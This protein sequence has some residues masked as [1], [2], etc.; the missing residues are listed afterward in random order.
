M[1][2][3]NKGF[4]RKIL[5][6]ASPT[7]GEQELQR[8][9]HEWATPFADRIEADMLGN[10]AV[11]INPDAKL[12]VMLAGHC[13]RIGFIVMEI[14]E[15]GY[16]R[17]DP[18]GGIDEATVLGAHVVIRSKKG[19]VPGIFGKV[20]THIQ[21]KEEKERVPLMDEVWIDIGA[22]DKEAAEKLVAVGDYAVYENHVTELSG[23]RIAS[24]ALDNMTGLY[25]IMQTAKNCAERGIDV[26]LY[27]VSTVQEEIGSRGAEVAGNAIKPHIAIA[28]DTT[29][30]IDTPGQPKIRTTPQLSLG[31]G[32]S[33]M[34]GPNAHPI[35][36]R[37]F[38]DAAKNA[39]IPYQLEVNAQEASNDAKSMQVADSGCA[40]GS[41][42][43]PLRNMHTQVEVVD[44]DDV[45][46]TVRL[47]TEFVCSL[48]EDQDLLPINAD[49]DGKF[50][51]QKPVSNAGL[52]K[53]GGFEPKD[54]GPN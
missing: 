52:G 24:P 39:N 14:T 34:R 10:M 15:Q 31:D 19:D 30:A 32:P 22:K 47:L 16:L 13:D 43:I 37:L 26:A 9:L 38:I 40:A 53:L 25:A 29:L 27:A 28:V 42:G 36:T 20:S 4:L 8:Y 7:G 54:K 35:V 49:V 46:N 51:D 23:S 2:A 44:M 17:V 18:L 11:V 48:K 3:D 21:T 41:I 33:I 12:R 6:L 50:V 5:S 1:T 45:E